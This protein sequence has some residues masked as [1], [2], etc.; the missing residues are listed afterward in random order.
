MPMI[1]QINFTKV[2]RPPFTAGGTRSRIL[3][4]KERSKQA[5]DEHL[6]FPGSWLHTL[7]P[8]S[9]TCG[10]PSTSELIPS[11]YEKKNRTF[12]SLSCFFSAILSREHERWQINPCN[13]CY[14]YNTHDRW[15]YRLWYHISQSTN[16]WQTG[17]QSVHL[18]GF[19]SRLSILVSIAQD[20]YPSD[21]PVLSFA[22]QMPVMWG[23]ILISLRPTSQLYFLCWDQGP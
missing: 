5:E 21:N 17:E 1:I 14:H 9:A 20:Q 13:Q 18:Q 16:S 11:S 8:A 4:L 12:V 2:R 6:S 3:D 15:G 7:H 22:L 19:V 10:L 23:H